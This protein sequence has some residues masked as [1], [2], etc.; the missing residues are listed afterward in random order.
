MTFNHM[1]N[2]IGKSDSSTNDCWELSR[3]CNLLDVSVIGGAS[4]LFR[5]FIKNYSPSTIISFSDI[6]HTKGKLYST[7][8]FHEDSITDPGYV[9][10]NL[11]SDAWF[12]RVSCQKRHLPR[13][14][15]E[16]DLDIVNK[17]EQM[18]MS[19]HGFVQVFDS[20]KIKWVWNKDIEEGSYN[21]NR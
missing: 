4:K 20:G 6:A 3:F 19:E 2:T 9:W 16:P 7:L 14:F 17:T 10:V 11:N 5:Y 18:I 15:N 12:N 21:D 1:R 13:L 8:N